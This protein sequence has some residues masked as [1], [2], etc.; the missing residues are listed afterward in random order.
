M[1]SSS[2]ADRR[3]HRHLRVHPVLHEQRRH[4]LRAACGGLDRPRPDLRV[5]RLGGRAAAHRRGRWACLPTSSSDATSAPPTSSSPGCSAGS[6]RRSSRRR[7][8]PSCSAASPAPARTS[9]WRR[10]SRPATT[11]STAVLKQGLLSDPIDKTLTFFVV[12][13]ILGALSRRFSARFPQGEAGRRAAEGASTAR[14][15]AARRRR[16]PRRD[17]APPAP[18]PVPPPEPADEGRR[19]DRRLASARSSSAGISGR[20]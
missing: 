7:S 10:S 5:P 19:R 12:F 8:R 9:S 20:S 6:S 15:S 3:R 14:D 17:L 13:A 2:C 18:S 1:R 11:S 16:V 4:V